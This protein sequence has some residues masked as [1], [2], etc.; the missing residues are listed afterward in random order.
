MRIDLLRDLG[1][2]EEGAKKQ[3]SSDS[4]I[5]LKEEIKERAE[6]AKALIS[7]DLSGVAFAVGVRWL[8]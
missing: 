3:T 5:D 8:V 6:S 1:G 2:R 4:K 7:C